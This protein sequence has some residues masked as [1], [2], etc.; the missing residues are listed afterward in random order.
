MIQ[1]VWIFLRKACYKFI[2]PSW[3]SVFKCHNLRGV[4][5]LTRLTL[6]LSHLRE[7]KLKHGFE[8]K[9]NPIFS[10][11]NDIQTSAHFLLHCSHYS[12][13][14]STFLD[15][16]RNIN[17]NIVDKNDLQITETLLYRDNSLD[18]KSNTLILNATIE[19]LFVTKRLQVKLF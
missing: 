6:G 14:R 11:G 3:S 7:H 19:F 4:Q 8:D 16:I 1:K 12:N 15:T 2:R 10:C 9:L 17:R 18:N 13:E 5:L